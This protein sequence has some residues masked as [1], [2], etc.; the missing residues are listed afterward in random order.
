MQSGKAGKKPAVERTDSLRSQEISKLSLCQP[1][2]QNQV[3]A[4]DSQRDLSVNSAS[5]IPPV[6]VLKQVTA[7]ESFAGGAYPDI[8]FFFFA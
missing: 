5:T 8:K 3:S 2:S 4:A 1:F 6:N 7:C